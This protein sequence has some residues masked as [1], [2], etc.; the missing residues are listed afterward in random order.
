MNLMKHVPNFITCLNLFA[1]CLACVTVLAHH[2]QE[3]AFIFIVLAAVFDF[4]DGFAARLLKAYSSIG[5]ELDSLAD[6]VSFGVAPGFMVYTYLDSYQSGY[7]PLLALLLPVF[8]ALRLAKF[9]VDTRQTTSFWGLPVPACALYWASMILTLHY[10]SP[11]F[12]MVTMVCIVVLLI[13]F[14]LLMV[15]EIPMLSLKFKNVEW[16]DNR[17]AFSIIII[18]VILIA[19]CSVDSK[20]YLGVCLSII[21]YIF[22]SLAH[23]ILAKKK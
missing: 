4:F 17:W 8:A 6:V 20:P 9:N 2:N 15:S 18:S 16:K 12:S 1:G 23:N 5:A 13:I 22:L 21:V 14:C 19:W 10:F 3:G 7:L 11:S